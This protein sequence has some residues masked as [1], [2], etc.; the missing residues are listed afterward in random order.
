M[1]AGTSTLIYLQQPEPDPPLTHNNC[2]FQ[3]RLHNVQAYVE[4]AWFKQLAQIVCAT[5]VSSSF[6]PDHKS[7]SIH[8]VATIRKNEPGLLGLSAN[9]TDWLP[10]VPQHSVTLELKLAATMGNPFGL[11]SSNINQLNLSSKLALFNPE[12]AL[13]VKIADITAQ[14]MSTLAQE[15]SEHETLN[16]KAVFNVQNLK[17]GHYAALA[18]FYSVDI[19]QTLLLNANGTLGVPQGE[20]SHRNNYAVIEIA[21]LERRGPEAAR[22][23][24]WWEALQDTRE[25][26]L[27]MPRDDAD[28]KRAINFAWR[29]AVVRAERLAQKDQ[30]FLL[31][32]IKELLQHATID[33]QRNLKETTI[34]ESSGLEAFPEDMRVALGVANMAQ[35]EAGVAAY[36]QALARSQQQ[37]AR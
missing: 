36:E 29:E 8:R 31:R 14:I 17:A 19:P 34:L 16:L 28:D 9:L 18:P 23:Q 3:V 5:Q 26:I 20:L 13:G 2:Y 30:S 25:H 22:G 32:E 7:G 24:P 15:G 4:A 35:L 12:L 11:L 10:A 37:R 6:M 33:I 1:P 21:V 27:T